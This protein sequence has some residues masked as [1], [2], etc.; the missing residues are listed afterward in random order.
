MKWPHTLEQ[1]RTWRDE[2][3]AWAKR[4]YERRAED[5]LDTYSDARIRQIARARREQ[6]DQWDLW[7]TRAEKE[8][9]T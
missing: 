4:T 6:A 7:I 2:A 9:H 5:G 1:M 3:R 8:G